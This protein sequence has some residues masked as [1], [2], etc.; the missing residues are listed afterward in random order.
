[1]SKHDFVIWLNGWVELNGGAQPTAAQWKMITD[2]LALVFNKVTP[3]LGRHTVDLGGLGKI[4]VDGPSKP[5]FTPMPLNDPSNVQP[6]QPWYMPS[7]Q[8][9]PGILDKNVITC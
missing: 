7:P 1:M 3:P 8:W 5:L 9:Q 4:S 2:H 6:I